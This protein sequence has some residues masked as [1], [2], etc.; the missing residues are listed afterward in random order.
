MRPASAAILVTA[1]RG[2]EATAD[3]CVAF[4]ENSRLTAG[5]AV[6]GFVEPKV[7]AAGHLGDVGPDRVRAIPELC[8]RPRDVGVERAADRDACAGEL[9]PVA[10]DD[11]VRLC[12]R[13]EHV[14][15][16]WRRDTDSLP[17]ARR[18]RP[19]TLMLA[20][21]GARGVDDRAGARCDAVTRQEASV[22]VAGEEA[23]LLALGAAGNCEAGAGC[24]VA[25]RRLVL[26]AERE[27]DL[28]ELARVDP[29]EPVRRV[30]LLVGAAM[31]EQPAAVL[32]DS[33]VV[34]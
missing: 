16:L 6:G 21:R 30:L 19:V 28:P 29:G 1:G 4:V 2:D 17:L 26:L 10:D 24:F 7:E 11:G 22:V 31:E 13:L 18:E 23:R 34:A 8:V 3:D 25:R 5:D 14:E 33:R 27:P 12:I 15:R 9:R 32:G 20:E